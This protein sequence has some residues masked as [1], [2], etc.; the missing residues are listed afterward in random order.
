MHLITST[1][2]EVVKH[3]VKLRNDRAYRDGEQAVVVVGETLCREVTTQHPATRLFVRQNTLNRLQAPQVIELSDAAFFKAV[4]MHTTET[5]L[6][7]VPMPKESR[8]AGCERLLVFDAVS[9]PGNLGTLMRSALA[10]GWDGV[11]LLPGCVDPFNDKALRASR[12]APF[13]LPYR[14]ITYEELQLL[15][16][17]NAYVADIEGEP[18]TSD[19]V[20]DPLVLVM[21]NEARG[22]SDAVRS[23][24]R[25]IRIPMT[26]SVESLNVAAAGAILLHTL[27]KRS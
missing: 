27:Q 20:S 1:N 2:N 11:A 26:D 25:P 19:P 8:L 23:L 3:L 10:F 17:S 14:W 24:C 18:L 22:P 5:V 6:A 12:C 7:E 16:S 9:D 15:A 13:T 21:G 4:G